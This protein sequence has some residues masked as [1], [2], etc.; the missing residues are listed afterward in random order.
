MNSYYSAPL[1][2]LALFKFM[3]G[4]NCMKFLKIR[5]PAHI[6]KSLNR[7]VAVRCRISRE[8]TRLKFL[9]RC[10]N[11][12]CFPRHIIKA[13]RACKIPPSLKNLRRVTKS[14]IE[15][16]KELISKLKTESLGYDKIIM[17]LNIVCRIKLMNFI[18]DV[19]SK[20]SHKFLKTLTKTLVKEQKHYVFSTNPEKYVQNLSSKKLTRIETEALSLGF[21][22]HIPKKCNRIDTETQFE[23]LYQQLSE[24]K[25]MNDEKHS[26]LRS[27]LVDITNQY[28]MT[29]T[30]QS[31]VL[32][33]D[34]QLALTK[35]VKDETIM[36]LRPDKGSGVVVI[37][38]DEYISKICLL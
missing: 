36:L 30:P 27:K 25:P 35:L 38:R 4:T 22:F 2:V 34:H 20:T 3:K 11:D 16:T 29:P 10:L 26:W 32:T 6:F 14:Q 1:F 9:L 33:K 18:H 7:L 15:C 23:Y 19:Q 13:V 5:L 12:G 37:N 28:I 24:L 17:D 31:K 8:T 21:K